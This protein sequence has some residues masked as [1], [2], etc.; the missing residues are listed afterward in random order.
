MHDYNELRPRF[1]T[2]E[3]LRRL[4][5]RMEALG[6]DSWQHDPEVAALMEHIATRYAAL[7]RKHG[8]DRWDAAA[9]AFEAM[10]AP[11]IRKAIDPWAVVTRAVQVTLIAEDRAN[12]LLCS[13]HQARRPQY[14]VFHDAERFSDRENPLTDYHH[15]FHVDPAGEDDAPDAVPSSNEDGSMGVHTAVEDTIALFSAL[16][17]PPE[18]ARDAVEYACARLAES[19]SRPSAHESLRRDKHARALLD[20]SSESWN[21]LLRIVLGNPDPDR[22]HTSTGR[23]V[24]LR[25][26]VGDPLRRLFDEDDLVLAI[27]QSAPHTLPGG[28]RHG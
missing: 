14:S 28:E 23:G 10:R 25:L 27:G 15:A 21:V 7:A 13:P 3:G 1:E 18:T 17:W 2:S 24:L 22:A 8:L 26:L 4:L 5:N 19:S 9:A 11:S 12:G 6:R 16:G 20:L